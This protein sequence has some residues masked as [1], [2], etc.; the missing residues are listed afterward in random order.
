MRVMMRDKKKEREDLEEEE[1]VLENFMT[2][3]D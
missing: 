3:N 2:P 1:S